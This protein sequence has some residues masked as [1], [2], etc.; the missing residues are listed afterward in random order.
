MS[1]LL[2]RSR[3]VVQWMEPFAGLLCISYLAILLD[4]GDLLK[5]DQ[6]GIFSFL[7][8]C[9][10]CIFEGIHICVQEILYA[11]MFH[12]LRTIF[13]QHCCYML[14]PLDHQYNLLCL[15]PY[16]M[17]Y[18]S[19]GSNCPL[20]ETNVYLFANVFSWNWNLHD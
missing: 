8:W 9:L 15:G 2:N 11:N 16:H 5:A 3:V 10:H 12:F 14:L 17:P 18:L 13:V 7:H 6:L 19:Q 1:S 4:R 20:S